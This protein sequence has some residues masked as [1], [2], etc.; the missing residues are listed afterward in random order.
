MYKLLL[1][2]FLLTGCSKNSINLSSSNSFC[3]P[4]VENIIAVTTPRVLHVKIYNRDSKCELK[5][6]VQK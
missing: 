1:G 3:E 4:G 2:I 6:E 5:I